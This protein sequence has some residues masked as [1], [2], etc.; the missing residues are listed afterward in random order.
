VL[1]ANHVETDILEDM[2]AGGH[3]SIEIQLWGE[4]PASIFRDGQRFD[5]QWRRNGDTEMVSFY[6]SSG[7]ALPLDVG[8]SFVQLV[9]LGFDGLIVNP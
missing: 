2:V 1:A 5:G 7:N 3:Y 4:G 8:N 6:D 9:P